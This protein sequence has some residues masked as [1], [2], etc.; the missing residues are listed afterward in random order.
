MRQVFLQCSHA[1]FDDGRFL[2]RLHGR[3]DVL[4]P[5]PVSS[6]RVG[7]SDATWPVAS[8]FFKPAQAVA[9]AGSAKIPWMPNSAM[10]FRMSLSGTVR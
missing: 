10:A 1:R 4:Q 5:E 6:T 2:D 7:S 8:A 9:P 3:T